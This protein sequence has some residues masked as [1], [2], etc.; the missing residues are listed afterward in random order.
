MTLFNDWMDAP[1]EVLVER[2]SMCYRLPKLV[3]E[4]L[5]GRLKQGV[6]AEYQ[7]RFLRDQM[8]MLKE[9]HPELFESHQ[10][11]Q[12]PMDFRS[13]MDQDG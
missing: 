3:C 9:S 10:T 13:P 1:P 7:A 4:G 12:R 6:R 11:N 5:L 8:E 2:L